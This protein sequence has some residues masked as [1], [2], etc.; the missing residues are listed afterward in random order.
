[1]TLIFLI[2][3]SIQDPTS[4]LLHFLQ[5]AKYMTFF[6]LEVLSLRILNLVLEAKHTK[7]V[8][9][10]TKIITRVTLMSIFLVTV[11]TLI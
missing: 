5:S 4:C 3:V 9:S 1:M 7:D 11:I 8:F 10:K 6:V 2:V